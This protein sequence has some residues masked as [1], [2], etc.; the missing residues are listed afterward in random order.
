[1]T[2]GPEKGWLSR[3]YTY[4][5]AAWYQKAVTIPEVW[6]GKRVTL[7][8]ERPHWQSDVWIDGKPAGMRNSLA[9]PHVYDLGAALAP[10]T[11]RLSIRVD[12]TYRIE[13]GRNAHSVTEHTQT[14]W[15]GIVGRIELRTTDAVWI[16]MSG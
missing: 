13:V 10:G 15:N 2:F 7:F 14:N 9:T 8:L 5:G 4:E 16:E 11:H 6:R 3:P 12:N 1:M